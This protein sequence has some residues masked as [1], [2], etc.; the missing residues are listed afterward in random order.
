MF[1]NYSTIKPS[2]GKFL[3][4]TL[5]ALINRVSAEIAALP[6]EEMSVMNDKEYA[7]SLLEKY[8]LDFPVID[9]ESVT[10]S[11]VERDIPA[12]QFPSL[13]T[14]LAGKSYKRNVITYHIPY[15]GDIDI[16]Q[17]KPYPFIHHGYYSCR[18][19]RKANCFIVEL[20]DF[21]ND[22]KEVQK[23]FDDKLR[24]FLKVYDI[25]K[26]NCAGFNNSLKVYIK[27]AVAVKR[28]KIA[29]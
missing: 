23:A 24:G 18:V 16:L 6:D 27:C 5:P 7:A 14:K 2:G 8:A 26:K 1:D 29:I 25:L 19:D 13:F 11:S 21:N 20:V 10:I 12:R 15:K 4:D 28:T 22:P 3:D 17:F 9:I